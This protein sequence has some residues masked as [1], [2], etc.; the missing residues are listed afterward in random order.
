MA[1][2][3][4]LFPAGS[5]GHAQREGRP[6]GLRLDCASSMCRR[7]LWGRAPLCVRVLCVRVLC[8]GACPLGHVLCVGVCPL[9]VGARPLGHVLCVG[10]C[11]LVGAWPRVFTLKSFSKAADVQ[12]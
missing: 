2:I 5:G 9:C 1:F 10:A 12:S 7:V 8:V 6:P 11:P 4:F 3:P